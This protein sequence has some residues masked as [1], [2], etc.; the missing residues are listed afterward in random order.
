MHSAVLAKLKLQML[1]DRTG[2]A[3]GGAL[4]HPEPLGPSLGHLRRSTTLGSTPG[5]ETPQG[6]TGRGR[7]SSGNAAVGITSPWNGNPWDVREQP[8]PGLDSTNLHKGVETSTGV[9]EMPMLDLG[10]IADANIAINS[11]TNYDD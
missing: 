8:S 9:V 7:R 3:H 5:P 6:A 4:A 2:L 11:L 10:D 1:H